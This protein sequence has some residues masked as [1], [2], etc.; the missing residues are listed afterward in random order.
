LLLVQVTRHDE[1]YISAIQVAAWTNGH[2]L[3]TLSSEFSACQFSFI[4]P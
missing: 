1:K 2:C 4:P 3:K